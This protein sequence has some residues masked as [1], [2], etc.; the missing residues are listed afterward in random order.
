MYTVQIYY[1]RHGPRVYNIE[2][3]ILLYGDNTNINSHSGPAIKWAV[4]TRSI[5]NNNG[6]KKKNRKNIKKK[7]KHA[8]Y[9]TT[10]DRGADRPTVACRAAGCA[11]VRFDNWL[12]AFGLAINARRTRASGRDTVNIKTA[13]LYGFL[14][15]ARDRGG[16]MLSHWRDLWRALGETPPP[17]R[18]SRTTIKHTYDNS[19]IIIHTACGNY[20]DCTRVLYIN[21]YTY[22]F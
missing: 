10:S 20:D 3:C 21:I 5:K 22:M 2:V 7:K 17:P 4:C 1:I 13:N 8:Y 19:I 6:K 16:G 14:L 18:S 9:R 11:P 15:P 12:G